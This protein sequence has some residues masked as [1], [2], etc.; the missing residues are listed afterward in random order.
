MSKKYIIGIDS[1]TTSGRALVIDKECNI[2]GIGQQEIT[3]IYPKPAWVEHDANEI[4]EVTKN[5]IK[6]P[7]SLPMSPPKKS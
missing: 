2:L 4:W 6:M 7:W 3:Q 1:G 5:S